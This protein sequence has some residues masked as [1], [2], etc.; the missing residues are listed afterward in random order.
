[1]TVLNDNLKAILSPAAAKFAF[2]MAQ[3]KKLILFSCGTEEGI[4]N[5]S[6]HI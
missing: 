5:H 4:R 2:S 3:F 1:M 6:H